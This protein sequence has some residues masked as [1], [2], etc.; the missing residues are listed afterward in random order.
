MK[1]MPFANEAD[2]SVQAPSGLPGNGLP[3]FDEEGISCAN[4]YNG[5]KAA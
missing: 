5:K 3:F 4:G 1:P 2:H